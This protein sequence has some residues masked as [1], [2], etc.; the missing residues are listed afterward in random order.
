MK[1]F[2]LFKSLCYN[3]LQIYEKGIFMKR[4][5]G[6]FMKKKFIMGALVGIAMLPM[7][8]N[9]Q[10]KGTI[11][12][13]GQNNVNVG[14]EFKVNMVIDNVSE[15]EEGVVG[16]GGYIS[17]DTDL[18][19]IVDA[20]TANEYFTVTRNKNI[21]KIAGVDYSL[22][23][24]IY[25]RSTV[26]EITFKGLNEGNTTI[27]MTKAELV[28][29]KANELDVTTNG[30]NVTVNKVEEVKVEEKP[31]E[32]TKKVEKKQT[33]EVVIQE[34]NE[35]KEKI[36]VEKIVKDTKKSAKN[37]VNTKKSGNFITRFFKKLFNK[38]IKK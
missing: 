17:F 23:N 1:K 20:K 10:G 21:N 26:Y 19:E 33:Q 14:D 28:D 35:N 30:L 29:R 5:G 15:A 32:T 22:A 3:S 8:V 36:V 9:A 37:T 11:K 34:T 13:E 18:L 24:G 31:V 7:A 38:I 25:N 27:T 16:F 2:A 4:N 12:F 6:I